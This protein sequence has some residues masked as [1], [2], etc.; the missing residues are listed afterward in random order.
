MSSVCKVCCLTHIN[1]IQSSV[2]YLALELACNLHV[3][4]RYQNSRMTK[5]THSSIH[6]LAFILSN[7]SLVHLNQSHKKSYSIIKMNY[8]TIVTLNL[9]AISIHTTYLFPNI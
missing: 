1:C 9:S 3:A 6:A 8:Y 7:I 2:W 5:S 4:L